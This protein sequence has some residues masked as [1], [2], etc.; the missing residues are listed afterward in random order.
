VNGKIMGDL[1]RPSMRV[2]SSLWV[3]LWVGFEALL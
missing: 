1:R 3:K 2:Q